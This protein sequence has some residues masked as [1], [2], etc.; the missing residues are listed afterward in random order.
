MNARNM[1]GL[2]LELPPSWLAWELPP[3]AAFA[4][5]RE[6]TAVNFDLSDICRNSS[7]RVAIS[8]YDGTQWYHCTGS[9]TNGCR[10]YID[11]RG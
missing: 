3:V 10:E 7:C 2:V 9:V 5:H 8:G 1:A 11:R 4:S 6:F